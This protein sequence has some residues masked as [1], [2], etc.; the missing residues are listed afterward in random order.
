MSL[1]LS[2]FFLVQEW[3]RSPA[4]PLEALKKASKAETEAKKASK[5]ETEIKKASKTEIEKAINSPFQS[6]LLTAPAALLVLRAGRKRAPII[7]ALE[8]EKTLKQSID[9]GKS[10]RAKKWSNSITLRLL[11][12]FPI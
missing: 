5:A 11:Y 9:R 12:L 10:R 4:S 2:I 1:L 6:L 8:T 3:I 7:K